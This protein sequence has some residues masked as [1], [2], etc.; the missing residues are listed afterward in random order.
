MAGESESDIDKARVEDDSDKSP[1]ADKSD[2]TGSH[3]KV[4]NFQELKNMYAARDAENKDTVGKQE[5][6]LALAGNK[7][8]EEDDIEPAKPAKS[9][10]DPSTQRQE[11]KAYDS[12]S[13]AFTNSQAEE[14]SSGPQ[15][16]HDIAKTAKQLK[17]KADL[18][19]S[20][21]KGQ[22]SEDQYEQPAV[23]KLAVPEA[24]PEEKKRAKVPTDN[25]SAGDTCSY[26]DDFE[27]P[28]IPGTSRDKDQPAATRAQKV[29]ERPSEE[30]SSSDR[31]AKPMTWAD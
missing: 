31:D 11:D 10:I 25:V 15:T 18:M 4:M 13:Y 27:Q 7:S 5:D 2:V 19:E 6:A 28:S 8:S 17:D 29:E 23:P 30:N 12:S 20:K 24:K 3:E 14:N 9:P 26:E 21:S 1:A 16:A 22:P